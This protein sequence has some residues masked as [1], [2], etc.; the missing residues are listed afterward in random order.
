MAKNHPQDISQSCRP[1]DVDRTGFVLGE[2]AATLIL[3]AEGVAPCCTRAPYAQMVGYGVSTDGTHI[4]LPNAQGQ[5]AAMQA[6]L[7]DAQL[8]PDAVSYVNAH[9]TATDAGDVTEI[10]SIT[11]AFGAHAKSLAVSSTKSVHGHLIGAGGALEF[12][13]SV[14]ALGAGQVPPTAH[15]ITQDPRCDID[16]VPLVARS[17]PD[18]HAVMSNS[19]AFGGTNAS[20]IACKVS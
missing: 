18:M 11:Q 10:Q 1:F 17:I 9:G 20:L 14:M 3:E 15:L 13:L 6:A 12:A 5:V 19:F 16:C 7:L 2:G 8:P 4:T